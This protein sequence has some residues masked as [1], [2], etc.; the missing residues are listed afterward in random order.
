MIFETMNDRGLELSASD[1]LKNYLFGRATA[2]KIDEVQQKW[3]SMAGVIEAAS[4]EEMIVTYMRHYW[5]SRQGVARTRQLYEDIK[6]EINNTQRAVEFAS[7]LATNA[8]KYAAL[9]NSQHPIWLQYTPSARR[10]MEILHLLRMEQVRPLLLAV[11]DKFTATEVVKALKMVVC[12]SVR[13][14]IVGGLGGGTMERR[15]AERAKEI[16]DG[17]IKNAKQ[18]LG[19]MTTVVPGDGEFEEEFGKARVSQ[20]Y[21]ARYYRRAL[22]R[23][24]SAEKEPELVP[25]T[26]EDVITLEHVL[27]QNPG[28]AWKQVDAEVA[29]AYYR[30]IGNMALLQASVNVD[31]GNKSFTEKCAE[32]KKSNYALTKSIT[33]ETN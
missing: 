4:D 10:S 3:H 21:L 26:E 15:Y 17:K 5:L 1:L 30:R 23:K 24:N 6:T 28:K 29:S 12:W 8:V 31:L 14:L 22:E 13:F 19:A 18:L 11:L 33:K 20:H 25:N 32:F 2:A 9:L 27:P 16:R 7:E